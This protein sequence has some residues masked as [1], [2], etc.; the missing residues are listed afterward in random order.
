MNKKQAAEAHGWTYV[1][2]GPEEGGM[3]WRGINPET[4]QV[5][6]IP[7]LRPEAYKLWDHFV[8]KQNPRNLP[9]HACFLSIIPKETFIEYANSYFNQ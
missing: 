9:E 7:D 5:E 3:Y 2:G 8:T 1:H 4:K 6:E